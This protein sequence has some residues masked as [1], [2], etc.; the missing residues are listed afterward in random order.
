[1][2]LCGIPLTL[3]VTGTKVEVTCGK[4]ALAGGLTGESRQVGGG[5]NGAARNVTWQGV[6]ATEAIGQHAFRAGQEWETM[7][8]F[9]WTIHESF[10]FHSIGSISLID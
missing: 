7:A 2:P 10:Q 5:R 8:G 4:N 9:Y 1:M 3:S 6:N